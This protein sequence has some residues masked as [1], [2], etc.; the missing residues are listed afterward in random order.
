MKSENE[1]VI[2]GKNIAYL[3]KTL[4]L[5]KTKM[6]RLL[7]IGVKSLEKLENGIMPPRLN[8]K[9][10]FNIYYLFHIRPKD[11]FIPL[12]DEDKQV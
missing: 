8:V 9:I 5:S 10:L 7:G 1:V 12:Y 11:M 2:F 6:A 3:R 4:G